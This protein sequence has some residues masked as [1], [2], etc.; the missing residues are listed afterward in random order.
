M[1]KIIKKE[2]VS[3][4]NSQGAVFMIGD[5][6][7]KIK[8]HRS[9]T[10]EFEK[11]SKILNFKIVKENKK[12]KR[13]LAITDFTYGSGKLNTQGINIDKLSL[14]F[15]TFPSKFKIRS[16]GST[17]QNMKFIS[18]L[19]NI[20]KRNN[21]FTGKSSTNEIYYLDLNNLSDYG[22][23]NI[24]NTK[25]LDYKEVTVEEFLEYYGNRK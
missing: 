21:G 24:N 11:P 5:N 13:I 18:S 7:I 3:V 20:A 10:D 17:V 19:N 22:C 2:I 23:I 16:L 8:T 14:Y 6:V 15:E 25:A 9:R 4:Q 1:T 12:I